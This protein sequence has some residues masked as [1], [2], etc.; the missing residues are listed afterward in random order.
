[1]S[2]WARRY[3]LNNHQTRTRKMIKLLNSQSL[4]GEELTVIRAEL[5]RTLERRKGDQR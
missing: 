1:M 3:W 5:D 4:T 2:D